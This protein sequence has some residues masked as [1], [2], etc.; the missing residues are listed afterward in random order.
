MSGWTDL[1]LSERGEHQA[2]SLRHVFRADDQFAAIFSSPLK[3]AYD[4]ACA[5]AD[6]RSEIT[7]LQDLKELNCG[8]V[9]GLSIAHVQRDY[10]DNWKEN[11]RQ[12]N[13]DFRWPGGESYR[14][15]RERGVRAF[16]RIAALHPGERVLVVTHCGLISQIAGH[17]YGIS[18]ARWESYRVENGSISELVWENSFGTFK[19]FNDYAHLRLPSLAPTAAPVGGPAT[20]HADAI[21]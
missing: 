18:P 6:H 9:D 16:N 5:I 3:R 12:Q 8:R 13:A 17:L 21:G 2:A 20:Q 15:L 4:T 11:L 1:P 14:E 19:R 7:V 10:S